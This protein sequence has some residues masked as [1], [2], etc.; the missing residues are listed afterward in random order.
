MA[1]VIAAPAS[2]KLC[3]YKDDNLLLVATPR[4]PILIGL[5][6][7]KA[8]YGGK[9]AAGDAVGQQPLTCPGISRPVF[10]WI[11]RALGVPD[12]E[13]RS[14]SKT[15]AKDL[16]CPHSTLPGLTSLSGYA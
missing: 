15:C 1:R 12:G 11:R 7:R 14:R 13:E 3:P 10:V 2:T 6:G 9:T 8:G 4:K 16:L 5:Q